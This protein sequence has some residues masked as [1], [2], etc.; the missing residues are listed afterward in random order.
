MPRTESAVKVAEPH[1]HEPKRL[2][3][4][5]AARKEVGS[6]GKKVICA[7]GNVIAGYRNVICGHRKVIC[8]GKKAIAG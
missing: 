7:H 1:V 8:A 6:D 5:L 3:V 2:I 4:P